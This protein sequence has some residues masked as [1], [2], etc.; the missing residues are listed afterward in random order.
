MRVQDII[1]E[2]RD[3]SYTRVGTLDMGEVL[4]GKFVK[5]FNN[6]GAWELSIDSGHGG[7]PEL[8]AQPG[9]GIVVT[10]KD[11]VV[12]FS[13]PMLN[14]THT[15]QRDNETGIF[16]Y[17]GTDD[18]VHLA[19]TLAWP[20]PSNDD[21]T[22]QNV[23]HDVRSGP[24]ETVM[25]A[26]VNANIGP[27]APLSRSLA[28]VVVE[29][30]LARGAAVTARSRFDNLGQL[31][32]SI[33]TTGGLGFDLVQVDDTLEF[34]VFEPEDKTLEIRMDIE[35]GLLDSAKYGR[36]APSATRVIVAGQGEGVDRQFLEITDVTATAA[37]SDWGRR[38][39][40]FKDQRNTD[41]IDELTQAG[42]EI[43]TVNGRT[44]SVYTLTPADDTA[45]VYGVDW[46]L[47]DK[48]S[49]SAHGTSVEAVVTEA[50]FAISPQGVRVA[51][52]VGNIT[53]FDYETR[54]QEKQE[55]L[56]TR[57]ALLEKNA[58][59]GGGGGG[60]ITEPIDSLLW[61]TAYTGGSTAPAMLAWNDT[62]G[63]L[64]FQLKGGNVT[65]Q[66]GQ[67]QVVR[68]KNSTGSTLSNGTVV[69]PTG[70][71]GVNLTVAKSQANGETTSSKTFAVM[72][73]DVTNGN[74]GFATTFGLVRGLDTSALTEGAAVW[75]SPTTAGGL[76]STKPTA[77]NHMVLIGFCLRSHAEVGVIFVKI[78]NGFELDELHDVSISSPQAGQALGY[79]GTMWGN[80][81]G[82]VPTGAMM[83]WYTAT[84]PA[85]WQLCDGS[86]AAT[87]A[88]AAIVGANVPNLKGKVPVGLDAS[89][90]E[91]DVMG[92]TGGAKTVALT[93]AELPSHTHSI[94]HD[95]ASVSVSDTHSHTVPNRPTVSSG[96]TNGPLFESWPGGSGTARNHNT[97][98]DTHTHVVDLPNFTGTSGATGSGS[99]HNNLQPYIVVNYII[100]T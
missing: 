54:M 53:G 49:A 89:Q 29:A 45:M 44:Q 82:G 97:S 58:E 36:G 100:K 15:A 84:A 48:V 23:S 10:G 34:R 37:E 12:L 51:A 71:D 74:K 6:V 47:G 33:A 2:V 86:A 96:A 38:I 50:V 62:D 40:F 16:S 57:V 14:A 17:T 63:T 78:Q 81:Y 91:F 26:Y 41:V 20:Q 55:K 61:N 68:V 93:T 35:N 72:T 46:F 64:E 8:L 76:T 27:G 77:P 90:T 7:L 80:F 92:E 28:Q 65:L 56:D 75:L 25:K 42:N 43:I 31:L 70:T 32:G 24:A 59:A 9:Y 94:D 39:E 1:I 85:G 60:G 22:T 95:H 69:Y 4:D 87:S 79:N 21:V 67:E 98:S 18:N 30:D 13:G 19:D 52:A 83:M 5:R 3:S 73:E 11:G 66:I 99:A 88:L